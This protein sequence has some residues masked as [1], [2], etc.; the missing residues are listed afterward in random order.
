[1]V[2]HFKSKAGYRKWLAYGHIHHVFHG[3]QKV[4]IGG[5]LHKVKH[6]K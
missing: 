2:R 3:R 4:Y 6:R 1:M 5:R